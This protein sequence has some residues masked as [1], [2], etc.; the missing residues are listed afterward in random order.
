MQ[1]DAYSMTFL[2][3]EE[4]LKLK[5]EII[6]KESNLTITEPGLKNLLESTK[7]LLAGLE[8]QLGELGN[9]LTFES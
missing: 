9:T 6:E 8:L 2:F 3:K 1:Y 5:S 7:P 4:L